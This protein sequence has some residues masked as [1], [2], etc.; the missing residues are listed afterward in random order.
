[1]TAHARTAD[2]RTSQDAAA[3]VRRVAETH[4]LILEA[5][6]LTGPM[7][8]QMLVGTL[9]NYPLTESGVRSRRAELVAMGLLKDS[10]ETVRLPTGRLSIVWSLPE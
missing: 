5:F 8:D 1:M 7:H 3:S 2:P 9:R 4:K 6:R 10:G